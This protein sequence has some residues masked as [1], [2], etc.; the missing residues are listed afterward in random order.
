VEKWTEAK[1]ASI[2]AR[3]REVLAS[4]YSKSPIDKG[5][6][7]GNKVITTE[8]VLTNKSNAGKLQLMSKNTPGKSV[9]AWNI[10]EDDCGEEEDEHGQDLNISIPEL[11]PFLEPNPIDTKNVRNVRQ[12]T[13]EANT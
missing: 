9:E 13:A 5:N 2:K 8:A 12:M 4:E 1:E 10:L 6:S 7:M 3:E 11:D